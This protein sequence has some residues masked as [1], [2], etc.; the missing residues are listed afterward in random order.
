LLLAV[1]LAVRVEAV[2]VALSLHQ[3]MCFQAL[4]TPQLLA[5][6]ELVKHLQATAA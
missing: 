3:V 6:V 2:V 5:L 1:V 4:H